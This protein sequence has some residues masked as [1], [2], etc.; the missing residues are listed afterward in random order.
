MQMIESPILIKK[1]KITVFTNQIIQRNFVF[2]TNLLVD[3]FLLH[4]KEIFSSG[5]SQCAST[6]ANQ[7][8]YL[9]KLELMSLT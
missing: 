7:T 9:V 1:I 5:P 4:L 6:C 3:Y 8:N 2:Q